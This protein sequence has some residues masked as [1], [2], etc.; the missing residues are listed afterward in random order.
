MSVSG[1]EVSA[2]FSK[3]TTWGLAAA[4][5]K[6][7]L[8]LN[9]GGLVYDAENLVDKS[10]GQRFLGPHDIGNVRP[11]NLSWPKDARF[12]DH[13]YILE[14]LAMGSPAVVTLSNSASGQTASFRHVFDLAPNR[15]GL[16]VTVAFD[17]STHIEE[18]TSAKIY[19]F[20]LENGEGGVM[21]QTF[22]M[23]GSKPTIASTVNTPGQI[24]AANYPA[25]AGRMTMEDGVFRINLFSGT[26]LSASDAFECE[27]IKL[28]YEV[29]QDAPHVFGKNFVIAPADNDQPTLTVEVDFPRMTT[30]TGNSFRAARESGTPFKADW[31][32]TGTSINATDS[33]QEK[34]E[35]PYLQ[36][37]SFA[38]PAAGPG[39][40]K[41][42]VTFAARLAPTTPAG[43]PFLAPMRI[44]WIRDTSAHA[45]AA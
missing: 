45:F 34:F 1:R 25:V 33:F 17:K 6:G 27:R 3:A 23:L 14:A 4:V 26:T 13:G 15:A 10:F 20:E 9:D 12:T 16:F 39:Q 31:I 36:V 18:L 21:R 8:F 44:T 32:F 5:T 35:W 7:V 2:A 22:K 24:A 37:V 11:P 41:P 40:I 43:M 42:K 38:A 19:G 30:V 28:T 29:P